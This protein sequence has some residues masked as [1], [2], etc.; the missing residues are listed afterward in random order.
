MALWMTIFLYKEVVFYVHDWFKECRTIHFV[1]LHLLLKTVW[2][3]SRINGK[4]I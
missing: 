3:H 2:I 1:L 4:A